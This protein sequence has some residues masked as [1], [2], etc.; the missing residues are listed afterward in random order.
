[1]ELSIGN[2]CCICNFFLVKKTFASL[3]RTY[4]AII[5]RTQLKTG[6]M[7]NIIG[8]LVINLSIN[9]YGVLYFQLQRFPEW[10][11]PLNASM[12]TTQG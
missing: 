4:K 2:L 11:E 8:I 9:T 7:M 1:M 5:F 12:T 10:E 6:W 3:L